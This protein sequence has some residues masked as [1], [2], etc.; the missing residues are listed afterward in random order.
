MPT[1]AEL[2]E[3]SFVRRELS[4]EIPKLDLDLHR[5]KVERRVRQVQ[6]DEPMNLSALAMDLTT[7]PPV[8]PRD[9]P[10]PEEVTNLVDAF[11][12]QLQWIDKVD[13]D[14]LEKMSP[15]REEG[16]AQRTE[17]NVDRSLADRDREERDV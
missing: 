12:A 14:I 1:Q 4:V 2:E 3:A 9:T 7:L 17:R 10:T 5:A 11:V 13:D 16:K 8:L 6:P 15:A